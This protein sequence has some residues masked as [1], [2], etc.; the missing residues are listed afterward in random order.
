MREAELWTAELAGLR[1]DWFLRLVDLIRPRVKRL[2]QFAD[3]MRPFLEQTVQ[4]DAPAVAKH[5]GRPEIKEALSPL[6]D[7]LRT[8]EPFTAPQLE[9]AMRALA[10]SR[11]V[12]A[13]ALIHATRVAVTGRAVS[14]GLFQVLELMGRECVTLRLGE[15]MNYLLK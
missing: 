15:A 1:H 10:E 3:E 11:G 4:Y 6:I 9:V 14:P 2:D 7:T 8:V 12:K 5:L 13:A